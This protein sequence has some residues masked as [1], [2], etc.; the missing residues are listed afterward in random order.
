MPLVLRMNASIS[1]ILAGILPN[2]GFVERKGQNWYRD[3]D[4]VLHVIGL[5]KSRLG[6]SYYVN[7]GVWIKALGANTHPKYYACHIQQRLEMIALHRDELDSAL[8][9]EDYWKMDSEE[10]AR[11]LKLELSNAEFAFFREMVSAQAIRAYLLR[12]DS[13]KNLAIKRTLK[14]AWGLP[15]S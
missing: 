12:P 15:F 5:Q 4:D 8:N 9:E 13:E 2:L 11:V 10:R 14:E 3:L 6:E 7:L 1:N